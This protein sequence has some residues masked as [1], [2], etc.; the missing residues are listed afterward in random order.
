V[1]AVSGARRANAVTLLARA[2]R[3]RSNACRMTAQA[4]IGLVGL[5]VMGQVRRSILRERVAESMSFSCAPTSESLHPAE[6]GPEYRR[7]RI[8][9]ICLQPLV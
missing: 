1:T 8:S 4:E 7:E 9:Y 2:Q 3:K 5:A 6:L